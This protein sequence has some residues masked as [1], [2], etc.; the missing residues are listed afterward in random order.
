MCIRYRTVVFVRADVVSLYLFTNYY[1]YVYKK[2]PHKY[3]ILYEYSYGMKK[4]F[5]MFLIYFGL[6]NSAQKVCRTHVYE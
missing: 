4:K 2:T 5:S 6:K 1:G 3:L